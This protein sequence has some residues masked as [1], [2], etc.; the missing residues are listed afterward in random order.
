ML[1]LPKPS[2]YFLLK[3]VIH[4]KTGKQFFTQNVDRKKKK[5]SQIL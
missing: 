1:I 3:N 2:Q 4:V 5:Y